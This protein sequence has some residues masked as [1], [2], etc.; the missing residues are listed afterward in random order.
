MTDAS[1]L[2]FY[3]HRHLLGISDLSPADIEL[4]LDRADRAVAISRQSEK[5]TSTLRG[6]TQINLF[7]EASTRTQSSFELAGKRLGADVMN[8]SVASSSVKKGETLIDTAMTLNAMRPDILIIR[9]QSA[10]AA[11]LLAQK[12]G[13]SVV[14]A[15][16]GAHEHPTQALLDALTIRRAKG[17]LSKLIVAICGDILHSRVARSNIML[18]NALGAQVRVVAPSTLLPSGIERMGVI[19]CRSMAEGLK[20]ADVVMMLRLQRERMEGAFVPS[21]REY[22]RYFGL[23]AE[24]LKAAKDDAL[25]MHPGPMNRGVEIAS[26]IADGPQSVIQ[27]QVEMGVA[28]RMAVMEALL[29]PRRNQEGR[30]QGGRGA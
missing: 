2:P 5:K 15:G 3:P 30:N 29:D 25:V 9:H 21:V 20:D 23:D 16:D 19:A 26:E 11:A 18:L 14:N 28:V 13:C 7:Y 27:E 17:P 4:L 24:K 22:F 12:V 6:R 1:S 10:G 8:M